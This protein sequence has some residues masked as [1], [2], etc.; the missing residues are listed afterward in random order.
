MDKDV[1]F[2][3]AHK[4]DPE[5][6]GEPE[7]VRG[8]KPERRRLNAMVSVRLTPDEEDALRAEAEKRGV[9]LSA[10]V[11]QTIL[12]ELAPPATVSIIDIYGTFT[13]AARS[14]PET[15]PSDNVD[16]TSTAEVHLKKSGA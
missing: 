9:S 3:Q 14:L 8:Q 15:H 4:D 13:Q 2:Y 11:R 16:I 12:R 6:W 7:G 5:V 1:E 10:L